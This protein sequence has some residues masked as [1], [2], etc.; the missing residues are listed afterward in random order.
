MT[1]Y[2]VKKLPRPSC[3]ALLLS[4]FV[5]G[6]SGTE[7]CDIV[8]HVSALQTF[9]DTSSENLHAM[10]QPQ[11]VQTNGSVSRIVASLQA[12]GRV[13][14]RA[15][16]FAV[17]Q[18]GALA[19]LSVG[20]E[21]EEALFT[22]PVSQHTPH[23]GEAVIV[24]VGLACVVACCVMQQGGSGARSPDAE[25]E[26]VEQRS[27]EPLDEDTYRLA[28]VLLVRDGQFLAKGQGASM[29]RATRIFGHVGLLMITIV[30]QI[31]LLN[32]I[33]WLVT[34]Q[35]VTTIRTAYDEF[36]LKMCG[37][38]E[39]HTT[40]TVNGKHRCKPQYFQPDIFMGLDDELKAD[41]CNIPFS[42][43]RF[44]KLVLLIWSL[45]C[46]GQIK[47]CIETFVTLMAATPS[48]E[49]MVNAVQP[50]EEAERD[51][52]SRQNSLVGFGPGDAQDEVRK[53]EE[54]SP[55]IEEQG[56]SQLARFQ[57]WFNLMGDAGGPRPPEEQEPPEVPPVQ[58]APRFKFEKPEPGPERVITAL[59]VPMKAVIFG[60]VL[61]PWFM[62]TCNLLAQGSRWLTATND[63]GELILNAVG[64]EFVLLLKDLVYHTI[65]AERNKRELR[66]TLVHPI[67]KKEPAGYLVFMG[68]FIWGAMAVLWVYLYIFHLQTVLPEYKWDVHA[69]CTRWLKS[70]TVKPNLT[71]L[72]AAGLGSL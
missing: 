32:Q 60:T 1:P 55:P 16:S 6:T 31:V 30:I 3:T 20:S 53:Q 67:V 9:L 61:L 17:A 42:Q 13:A 49:S 63:F 29:L 39:N 7:T 34:P 44:F 54:P 10:K 35:A 57:G 66:N 41:V 26:E 4:A 21:E 48:C 56:P 12:V 71:A 18:L 70:L 22:V 15:T 52:F 5:V 64:L 59:T 19:D 47:M 33:K 38:V 65:V 8:D 28:I 45:T 25:E 2:R 46:I 62:I 27:F 69:S 23:L 58:Q 14:D 36:E 68:G 24:G 37:G 72:R 51:H 11:G 50:I 43:L 40:L